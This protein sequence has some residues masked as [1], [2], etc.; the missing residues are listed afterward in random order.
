MVAAFHCL[1]T[2]PSLTDWL[3]RWAIG[4]ANIAAP[5]RRNHAGIPSSPVTV[6]RSRSS[7]V[8]YLGFGKEGHG[9]RAER[10]LIMGIWGRSP[11]RGPGA[12]PLARG[13][14]GEAPLNLKHYLLLN[15]QWKLQIRPFFLKFGNAENHS[16]ISDAISH[17]DFNRILYRYEKKTIKH[18]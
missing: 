14:G 16:V 7:T 4:A 6:G 17:G 5:S 2:I 8:A 12:E 13:Q 18:C 10:E 3:N 9:E 1:G 15:V 11:Q